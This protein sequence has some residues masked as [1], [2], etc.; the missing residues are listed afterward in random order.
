VDGAGVVQVVVM[1][2][3]AD[4]AVAV[5]HCS[6]AAAAS[7]NSGTTAEN[8]VA[9]QY[10]AKDLG[11]S[12]PVSGLG[13]TCSSTTAC[14]AGTYTVPSSGYTITLN[15]SSAYMDVNVKHARSTLLAGVIGFATN[16][17]GVS[18][19]ET[20]PTCVMCVLQSTGNDTGFI[21]GTGSL[22]IKQPDREKVSSSI[23]RGT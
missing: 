3:P 4:T 11:F 18:A 8:Y 22:T 14:P 17:A 6:V 7:A 19:S 9:M 10:L 1:I 5:P 20:T 13:C 23:P 21:E 2:S 15:Q 12:L 16:G